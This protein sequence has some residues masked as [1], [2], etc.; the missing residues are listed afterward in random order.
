MSDVIER[1][2]EAQAVFNRAME[3][4]AKEALSAFKAELNEKQRDKFNSLNKK[5]MACALLE[6]NDLY[7]FFAEFKGV[8]YLHPSRRNPSTWS[9]CGF[10]GNRSKRDF[11]YWFE[12]KEQAT[13]YIEKWA[14]LQIQKEI[15]KNEKKA[16]KKAL[17]SKLKQLVSIGDVFVSSWGWEQTNIDYFKVVGFSGE[18]TLKLVSIGAH[19]KEEAQAMC[20]TKTPD[21][22]TEKGEVFT[23]RA[24]VEE[25]CM[26][27]GVLDVVISFSSYRV[28]KL[29]RKLED[30]SYSPDDYTSY[31]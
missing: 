15:D 19:R 13:A 4:D 8:A 5:R 27:N 1:V 30:G 9:A 28:A 3:V 24:E 29:K 25:N 20:G 23:K 14:V 17:A 12:T 21:V 16:E 26:R 18:S 2:S 6:S 22:N 10:T 7:A 31:A 11:G